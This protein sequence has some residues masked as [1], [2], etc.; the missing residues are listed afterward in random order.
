MSHSNSLLVSAA[1]VSIGM[2]GKS[3]ALPIEAGDEK[4]GSPDPKRPTNNKI[5]KIDIVNQLF[6]VMNNA[7]M[8]SRVRERAA[9]TL[10]LLCIGEHFPHTKLIMQGF[11][12]TAKEVIFYYT[13]EGIFKSIIIK[14][15]LI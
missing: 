4:L 2:L 15:L 5:S 11:L 1:C 10:G 3:T 14:W 13:N 8:Q 7:K 9:K 12:N 6:T